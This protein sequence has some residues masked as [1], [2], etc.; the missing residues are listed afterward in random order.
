MREDYAIV[1]CI[2]ITVNL[3]FIKL[4]FVYMPGDIFFFIN[5]LISNNYNSFP[6]I[7]MP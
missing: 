3:L 7:E 6:L 4:F 1:F 5:L 2:S